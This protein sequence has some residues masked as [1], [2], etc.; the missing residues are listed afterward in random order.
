[1]QFDFSEPMVPAEFGYSTRGALAAFG[2]AAC[3]V[4]LLYAFTLWPVETV[5]WLS[6]AALA[7]FAGRH[8]I[9]KYFG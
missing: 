8:P 2:V 6:L 4:S 1:M 3:A 9:D 5:G 7:R